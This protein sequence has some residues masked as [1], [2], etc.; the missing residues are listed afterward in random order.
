M[1]PHQVLALSDVYVMLNGLDVEVMAEPMKEWHPSI[2]AKL[3]RVMLRIMQVHY[4]NSD[5][6]WIE[7][8]SEA[9]EETDALLPW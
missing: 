6:Y 7:A 9:A 2:L 4:P 3:L 8:V 5:E 1:T